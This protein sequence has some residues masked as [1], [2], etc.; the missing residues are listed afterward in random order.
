VTVATY[1]TLVALSLVA[2]L[3]SGWALQKLARD[4]GSSESASS[5]GHLRARA[6]AAAER[7]SVRTDV[8]IGAIL[9]VIYACALAAD[10][11]PHHHHEDAS[12]IKIGT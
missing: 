3:A 9:F 1:A 2:L 10:R 5:P 6:L 8:A 4:R 11:A 12:A 7:K